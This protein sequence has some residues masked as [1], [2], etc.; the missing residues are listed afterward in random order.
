MY[1]DKMESEARKQQTQQRKEQPLGGGRSPTPRTSSGG[2]ANL[3][4]LRNKASTCYQ[5]G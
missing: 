2:E 3:P 1:G 5:A 4:L